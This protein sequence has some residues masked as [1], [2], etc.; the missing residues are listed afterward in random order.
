[1]NQRPEGPDHARQGEQTPIRGR[2]ADEVAG[3]TTNPSTLKDSADGR[4]LLD[5]G[6]SRAADEA[7]QVRTLLQQGIELIESLGDRVD[8]ALVTRELEKGGSVPARHACDQ[9]TSLGTVLR[10]P[11]LSSLLPARSARSGRER[12][13]DLVRDVG[14][15]QQRERSRTSPCG[16]ATA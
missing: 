10:H 5:G 15:R 2:K 14:S 4:G 7:A 16:A 12:G 13:A 11:S 9:G 1:L 3:Q 6:E 8:L